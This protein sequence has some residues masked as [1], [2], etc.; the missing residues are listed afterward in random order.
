MPNVESQTCL[1]LQ[2]LA[3]RADALAKSCHIPEHAALYASLSSAA[4]KLRG[5][6]A[7]EPE[8]VDETTQH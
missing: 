3:E 5:L 8:N 1:A 6:I 7:G 2:E 4:D